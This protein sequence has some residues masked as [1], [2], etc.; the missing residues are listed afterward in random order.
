MHF[1]PLCWCL[2]G[3]SFCPLG[4]L[5]RN[6]LTSPAPSSQPLQLLFFRAQSRFLQKAPLCRVRPA[7]SSKQHVL[8]PRPWSLC[9]VSAISLCGL[10]PGSQRLSQA[11][12]PHNAALQKS[13]H[14]LS[15]A[16][17]QLKSDLAKGPLGPEPS[18]CPGTKGIPAPAAV[19]RGRASGCRISYLAS[20]WSVHLLPGPGAPC[21]QGPLCP[22]LSWTCPWCL[23]SPAAL[24]SPHKLNENLD[25][26][27]CRGEEEP[28][29]GGGQTL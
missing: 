7:L 29:R 6:C 2:L 22:P 3:R 21:G 16:W 20:G 4:P 8:G 1:I 23:T 5:S 26:A 24:C 19:R 25:E 15:V 14:L 11:G 28:G 10:R 9:P 18:P 17:S 13:L 12:C 27:R